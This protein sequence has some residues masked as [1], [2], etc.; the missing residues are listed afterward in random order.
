MKPFISTGTYINV[1]NNCIECGGSGVLHMEIITSENERGETVVKC[2]ACS[3]TGKIKH[4][5]RD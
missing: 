4:P 1:K 3:G 5:W 2:Q